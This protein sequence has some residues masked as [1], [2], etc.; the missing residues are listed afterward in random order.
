MKTSSHKLYRGPGR[1]SIS[2]GNRW[3]APGYLLFPGL[4]PLPFMLHS[5]IEPAEF[6]RLYAG[7]LAKLDPIATWDALHQMAN[8][9]EPVLMC[10]E[11]PPLSYP[12]NW[13]H[14]RQVAEWFQERLGET[15]DELD[16]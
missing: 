7:I 15:V 5:G 4:M 3:V 2:R 11:K 12:S 16:V 10:W 1:I 14:R 6:T 8:G 9:A 13:C